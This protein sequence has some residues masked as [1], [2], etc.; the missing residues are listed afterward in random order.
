MINQRINEV[1]GN[2]ETDFT[3]ELL[4]ISETVNTF[5]NDKETKYRIVGIKFKDK[6]GKMQSTTAFM[7]ETNIQK[8][9]PEIGKTYLATAS[10][11]D[12]GVFTTVSA[13]EFI[14]NRAEQSMFDFE[15]KEDTSK[16]T[17]SKKDV[18]EQKMS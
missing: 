5:K 6:N 15:I 10:K 1:T 16:Q 9:H 2:P 13:I 14:D 18:I 12:R 7:Y 17:S 8:Y 4:T 3:A 11:T